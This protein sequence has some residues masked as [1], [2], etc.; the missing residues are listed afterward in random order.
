M[1]PLLLLLSL[2]H[3]F[4]LYVFTLFVFNASLVLVDYGQP[5]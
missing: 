4:E 1:L 5:A 3:L 2:L